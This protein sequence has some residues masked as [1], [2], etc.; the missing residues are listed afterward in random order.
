MTEN[1]VLDSSVLV[2]SLV[3]D[4]TFRS[5]AR[6]ILKKVF[7]G[8]YIAIGSN[9]TPPEVIGAIS[10]RAGVT[11]ARM[12]KD[13]IEKWENLGLFIFAD[14]DKRRRIKAD[15]L[16][17]NLR[18]RGMDAIIIQLAKEK[19]ATLV[20]FDN[21]MANRTRGLIKVLTAGDIETMA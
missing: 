5:A 10:R 21:E 14:L 12:A 2:S 16:A 3:T 19:N 1:V 4:D 15:E 20:T 6:L 18:V 9:I 13:Q 17:L 8:Y 7:Q 11:R